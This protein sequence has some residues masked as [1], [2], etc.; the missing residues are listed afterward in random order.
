MAPDLQLIHRE[1]VTFVL[2]ID[3]LMKR[4]SEHNSC[5]HFI[6][7]ENKMVEE[8]EEHGCT[9]GAEITLLKCQIS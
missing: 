9:R 5:F 3:A 4:D 2:F 6:K 8:T 1:E 7:M